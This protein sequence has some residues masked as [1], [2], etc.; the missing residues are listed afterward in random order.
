MD[1]KPSE[2]APIA[3]STPK[4]MAADDDGNQ[5]NASEV[6]G[7]ATANQSLEASPATI[8]VGQL[9]DIPLQDTS[10]EVSINGYLTYFTLGFNIEKAFDTA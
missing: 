2:N 4:K 7:Y 8:P 10:S 9:I 3:A 1:D 5:S 6:S